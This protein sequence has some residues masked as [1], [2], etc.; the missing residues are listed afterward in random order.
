MSKEADNKTIPFIQPTQNELAPILKALVTTHNL[1][2]S[3]LARRTGI[4]QPVI[5]R[6]ISGETGNP[7]VETLR[8]IAQ[9]FGISISQLIGDV[10]L[11]KNLLPPGSYPSQKVWVQVPELTWE[12]AVSWPAQSPETIRH[13]ISTDSDVSDNAYALRIKDSS[14]MPR[15]SERTIII[16]DPDEKPADRDYVIVH[17][18]NQSQ[19][20]FKQILIDGD[21]IYLKPLNPDFKVVQLH[22]D[23]KILGVMVQARSDYKHLLPEDSN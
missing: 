8:P 17:L 18:E 7:K 23:Y 3:E 20:I 12:Q 11:P 9:F 2:E 21:D 15:F 13:Y 1:S 14:M 19:V 5:H 10:P 22:Q 6:V 4:G 16:I